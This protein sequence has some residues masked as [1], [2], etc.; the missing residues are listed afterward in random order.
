MKCLF[1]STE[2]VP[3]AKTGG[4]AD[5]AGALPKELVKQGLDVRVVMPYYRQVKEKINES[6]CN[7]NLWYTVDLGWRTQG[8]D[9]YYDDSIVP[10]Y[11]L[12]NDHYFHRDVL[13]GYDD[14]CERFAF[15][16]RA[17]VELITRIDFVP[18]I[19]H[20]NDWQTGPI[21]LLIRDQYYWDTKYHNIK[22]VFTIH[23]MKYQGIFGEEALDL[24]GLNGGYSNSDKLEFNGGISFLKA[25]LIYADHINTVSPTYA[26]ELKTQQYGCG[27][28]SLI[29]ESLYWKTSGILNGIDTD[30]YD[31]ATDRHIY[32]NYSAKTLEDKAI[33]KSEFRKEYGLKDD[34]S[35]LIGIISRLTD[36]KGFDLMKH[37]VDHQWF[38]DKLMSLNVQF[39]V[40]G[41]GEYEYENM[42]KHFKHLYGDRAGVFLDFNEGLAQKI[43]AA[44]D[45]F[46]MP[47]EF[48]PCGLGQLMA[49][50]YGAVPVVR[51][52]GGLK[53]TVIHY[54]YMTKEGTGFE[55][56][57]Y[58]GYW[59]F[60][61]IEEAYDCYVNRPK[62]FHKIQLN[63]MTK[64][65]GWAESATKYADLYKLI[66]G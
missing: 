34:G 20:C 3:Y 51:Q 25:G 33:N 48:E 24:L 35:M 6:E 32:K 61:K 53:D 28:D 15:F 40:L 43:Y 50:R 2:V 26:E 52:T 63:G 38:M 56:T 18:D 21:P 9:V 65:Y 58:S 31:P 59:L 11:F 29:R 4:L 30:K 7:L 37:V 8:V 17:V 27:M 39:V 19:I 44:C 10:T 47:S 23:N 64:Q 1:V 42:F 55:F 5:V 57:D 66:K 41:T 13:Y 49:M 22:T 14:D 54:N 45:V 46:L 60:R 12:K 36:Q 16:C 62:D